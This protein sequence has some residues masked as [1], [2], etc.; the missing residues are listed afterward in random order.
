MTI[1]GL[2]LSIRLA[3]KRGLEEK[4][5]EKWLSSYIIS[6]LG[7][8]LLQEEPETVWARARKVGMP[9]LL[10]WNHLQ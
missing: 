6:P 3:K 7:L 1:R 2:G 4:A 10:F 5:S 8:G 9:I